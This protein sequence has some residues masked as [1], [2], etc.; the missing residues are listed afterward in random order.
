[1]LCR[2][3]SGNTDGGSYGELVYMPF[4]VGLVLFGLVLALVGFWRVGASYS[5]QRSMQIGAVSPESGQDALSALWRNWT[6]S[7]RPAGEFVV[8]EDSRTVGASISTSTR[9]NFYT[10]GAY[11]FSVSSGSQTHTRFER[12][13]P[14][15]PECEEASCNE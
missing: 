5:T 1:L 2:V 15:Q 7:S 12:F 4:L 11:S 14:G 9:F 3:E 10:L 6:N 8:D 13:Y